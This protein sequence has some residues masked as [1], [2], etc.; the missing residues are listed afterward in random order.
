MTCKVTVSFL[1]PY[2]LRILKTTNGMDHLKKPGKR[3]AKNSL[4][5]NSACLYDKEWLF[6][7]DGKSELVLHSSGFKPWAME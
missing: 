3:S 7:V 6:L 2:G 5:S 4:P 1:V